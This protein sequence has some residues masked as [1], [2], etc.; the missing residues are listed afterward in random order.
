MAHTFLTPTNIFR[1]YREAK[2]YTDRLTVPFPEFARM[3]DNKAQQGLPQHYPD[4]TSGLVAGIIQKVPKTAIQ[5]LPTG[6]VE[7]DDN[8]DWLPIVAQ[9][10]YTN[11]ILP[12][13]DEEY[14]LFEKCHLLIEA[15]ETFGAAASYTRFD[16]KKLSP[17]VELIYWGDLF[18]PAGKK[19]GNSCNYLFYRTWWEKSDIEALIDDE[20]KRA[21]AAKKRKEEY[22]P[23][24]DTEA[25]KSIV[26]DY[27][28]KDLQATTPTE[29]D[30]GLDATGIE[31][32]TGFQVGV[33]AKF[34]TFSPQ[35]QKI[36][37]TKI[38][39]DPRGKMPIQWFYYD[40]DGTN[41]LGR[42]I[43]QLI[44]PMVNLYDTRLQMQ[45]FGDALSLAP[46]VIEYMEASDRFEY[47]P[48]KVVKTNNSEYKVVPVNV[49]ATSTPD[50]IAGQNFLQSQ[51]YGLVNTPHTGVSATNSTVGDGKTPAA[52]DMQQNVLDVDINAVVKHF[53]SWWKDQSESLINCWFAER[54]GKEILQLDEETADKLQQL[55]P[56]ADFDPAKAINAQNQL[57]IDYD[58]A[59]P[60]LKFRV[61]PGT[62]KQEDD[63]EQIGLIQQAIQSATLQ[64][65][66]YMGQDGWKFNVGEAYRLMFDKLG[67]SD[68]ERIITKMTEEE[69]A[70][71]KKQ[72][73]PIIDPPQIRLT[74]QVPTSA[75]SAALSM[76]GVDT[77]NI[78]LNGD[79]LIDPGD[80][81]KATTDPAIKAQIEA[82]AGLQPSQPQQPIQPQSSPA[83]LSPGETAA[84]QDQVKQ[85]QQMGVPDDQIQ[86][87]LRTYLAQRGAQNVQ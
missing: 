85:W 39:N 79:Q 43:P 86:Q 36:V 72:P 54:H 29:H 38:N 33:G 56:T 31:L 78:Q 9:F 59:T 28:Q 1:R 75:M 55:T 83:S 4:V 67:I 17:D 61:N 8:N 34:Y 47:L 58:T 52:L 70:E 24:W 73:F 42:G 80:I 23:T 76:G 84:I 48:N 27:T 22:T 64:T 3:A 16:G 26:D 62:S 77:S 19:S 63:K 5:Q 21:A 50:F 57:I 53:E 30:R 10:I 51:I 7:T 81:Y 25:L 49:K 37:R 68:I 74:G 13:A 69:A 66:Y 46:P 15:G 60:A 45:A 11:K 20:S 35:S 82:M 40:I 87:H 32:V 14:S 71:A 6:L 41:P 2:R 44:G 65:V 18:I 12:L